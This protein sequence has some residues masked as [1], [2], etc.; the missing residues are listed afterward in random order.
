MNIRRGL[1]Q[2]YLKWRWVLD[3]Q[4]K[5][6]LALRNK[7]KIDD[8]LV[9]DKMLLEITDGTLVRAMVEMKVAWAGFWGE[10]KG[11]FGYER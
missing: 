5:L 11:R 2:H 9:S 8:L 7:L 1:R 10:V 4:D 6:I 3:K